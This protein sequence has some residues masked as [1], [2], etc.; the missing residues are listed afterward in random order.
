ME[1]LIRR[2]ENVLWLVALAA[3]ISFPKYL[4]TFCKDLWRCFYWQ[5]CCILMSQYK[6]D[7]VGIRWDLVRGFAFGKMYEFFRE[8]L[9]R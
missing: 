7:F 6:F 2:H 3:D 5:G 4:D 1:E 9:P 8:Q